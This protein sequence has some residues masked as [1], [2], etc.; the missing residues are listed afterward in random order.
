MIIYLRSHNI[1]PDITGE[2][3][4]CPYCEMDHIAGIPLDPVREDPKSGLNDQN[5]FINSHKSKGRS[6][7]LINSVT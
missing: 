5:S 3:S 6:T 2:V 1:G 7:Q 4:G